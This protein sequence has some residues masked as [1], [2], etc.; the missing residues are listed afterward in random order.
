M[1]RSS[2]RRGFAVVESPGVPAGLK[3][4]AWQCEPLI[5]LGPLTASG[6]ESTELLAGE[7]FR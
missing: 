7:W 2:S 3:Q 5:P 4:S 1:S 6:P